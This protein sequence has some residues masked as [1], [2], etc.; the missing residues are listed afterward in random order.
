MKPIFILALAALILLSIPVWLF[1]ASNETVM[2]VSPAIAVIGMETPVRVEVANPHG[3]REMDARVEQDGKSYVAST[4][5]KP[6]HRF[7]FLRERV[8]AQDVILIVGKK[9]APALHDGKARVVIEAKSND[10]RGKT[11]SV[12]FDVNVVT[13]PP[14]VVAD[15]AQ[16]YINQGGSELTVF[17]P[18]GYWTESG[19]EVGK[20]RYRSFPM[21]NDP[22]QRFSLF[23]YPWDMPV[24]TEPRV[25]AINPGGA[26]AYASFWHKITAKKFRS[27]DIVIDGFIEKVVNNI[28]PQGSGD[29]LQRFLRINGE[30]RRKNNETLAGLRFQTE[31]KM[32]WSGAFLPLVDSAVE[33]QFAD[34][35]TYIYKGK[36]VD[37]QVHLGFDLAKVANTPI[38]ASNDGKVVWAENIGIY[39]NCVVIDHG[40]GLQ[41]I[42]G[43]LSRIEVKVGAMVK[44]GQEIGRSGATGMAAGDHLHYSMQVDGVEVNPI[45]WWDAHWI[46]DRI[47]SKLAPGA[48]EVKSAPAPRRKKSKR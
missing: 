15:G 37:E 23:A 40:I 26:A 32:L 12:A 44:R 42:Y 17:T 4:R 28:D 19:V 39:G 22:N 13:A 7:L 33:S 8:P 16:H 31:P 3:V 10:F 48:A 11:D 20:W 24:T 46:H 34:K 18:S 1:F 25:Y 29:L 14:R 2:K 35:R 21:P 9:Q 45:E 30:M 27:R 41:S 5:T 47:M 36:K 6:A 38:P 43:H